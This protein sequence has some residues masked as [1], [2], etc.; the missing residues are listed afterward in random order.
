MAAQRRPLPSRS[1][2]DVKLYGAFDYRLF[3]G[4]LDPSSSLHDWFL[5]SSFLVPLVPLGPSTPIS[6]SVPLVPLGRSLPVI[7]HLRCCRCVFPII[8]PEIAT[9]GIMQPIARQ[10]GMTNGANG[11]GPRDAAG[12]YFARTPTLLSM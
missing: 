8:G 5:R 12:I 6:P 1:P 4:S 10:L 2:G 7:R 9:Y 3:R 11:S